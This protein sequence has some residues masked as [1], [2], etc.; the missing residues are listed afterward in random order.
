MAGEKLRQFLEL[1]GHIANLQTAVPVVVSFAASSWVISVLPGGWHPPQYWAAFG[2]MFSLS[3]VACIAVSNGAGAIR[4]RAIGAS[5]ELTPDSGEHGCIGI[6]HSG[7][8][9]TVN[10]TGR[11]VRLLDDTP[12]PSPHR[13]EC[14]LSRGGSREPSRLFSDGDWAHIVLGSEAI[15]TGQLSDEDDEHVGLKIHRGQTHVLVPDSGAVVEIEFRFSPPLSG[16]EKVRTQL[17][18]VKWVGGI[19]HI[20]LL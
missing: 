19:V 10:A 6:R 7:A 5:I 1:V 2:L 16:G 13:F 17:V 3:W 14:L 4:R 8:P 11:I 18:S 15:E 9:T 12:N 20:E